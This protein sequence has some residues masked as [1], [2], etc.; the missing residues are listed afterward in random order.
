MNN[1]LEYI[2]QRK[3]YALAHNDVNQWMNEWEG[4]DK[5]SL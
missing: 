2:T 5:S 3:K 4:K 1:E